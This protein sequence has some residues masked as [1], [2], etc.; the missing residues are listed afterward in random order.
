MSEEKP[1]EETK[2]EEPQGPE[3]QD[4]SLPRADFAAHI[5]TIGMQALIFCGKQP[6]PET[7]KYERNLD[8]A[9][10]QIDMLGI[11]RDK[12]K[13]NL[14]EDEEQLLETLLHSCHLAYLDES[15]PPKS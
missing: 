10:Y 2:G 8:L 7:G 9:R 14:S 1:P 5:Y 13:G 6:H 11:L 15:T 3:G 4:T 12:T